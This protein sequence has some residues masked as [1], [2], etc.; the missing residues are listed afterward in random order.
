MRVGIILSGGVGTRIGSDIPKQYIEVGGKPI[1]SYSLSTLADCVDRLQVVAAPEWREFIQKECET[2]TNREGA[3]CCVE[4]SDPGLTRQ[5]SIYN[6]L[7]DIEKCATTKD[8]VIIHDAARPMVS[9]DLCERCFIAIEQEKHDGAMPVIPVKDT[10]YFSMDGTGITSLLDRTKLWAGQSPEAFL[11]GKY[12]KSNE[13]L[14]TRTWE[15]GGECIIAPT[16]EIFKING[17]TEPAKLAGMD[18]I[19]IEGEENNYKITTPR[20]LERFKEDMM[21]GSEKIS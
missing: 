16:S 3:L 19:M 13:R 9:K 1:I 17:S 2:L 8:S 6:A 5:F 14:I 7:K 10:I 11:F 20:D 12:L 15:P 18:V 21:K 4:F